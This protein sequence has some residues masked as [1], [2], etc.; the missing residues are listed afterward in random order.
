MRPSRLGTGSSTYSEL[1]PAGARVG[2]DTLGLVTR[3]EGSGMRTPRLMTASNASSHI[4]PKWML[5]WA[6]PSGIDPFTPASHTAHD[7]E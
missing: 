4:P 2:S 6:A 5:W 3:M 1:H 7:G